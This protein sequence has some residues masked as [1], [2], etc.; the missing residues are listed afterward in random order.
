MFA[1]AFTLMS[2]AD[3]ALAYDS[4]KAL[5]RAQEATRTMSALESWKLAGIVVGATLGGFIAAGLGL[6][7]PLFLQSIP[8][9]ISSIVALSLVEA[10][11]GQGSLKDSSPRRYFAIVS[12]GIGYL[13][14]HPALRAMTLDMISA[15]AAAWLI[16]WTFQP[17]LTRSGVPI[18]SFGVMQ[19]AMALGQI[20]LLA[21]QQ[22]VEKLVG[23][24]VPMLRLTAI[25]P[26]LGFLWL[27]ATSH[28][29]PSI[30][31]ILIVSSFGLSRGPLFSGA[32]NRHIPSEERATVLSAVSAARTLAIAL[33]YP[34]AG[35]LMDLSLP[36]ALA[37]FGGFGL[38]VAWLC[39]APRSV[40]EPAE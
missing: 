12:G 6:R 27:A 2:G 38:L 9:L 4:L 31:G 32:L 17:Q 28:P 33:I 29:V 3:E 25:L 26:A 39:A 37:S 36:G 21:R 15:G 24:L 10:P 18:A 23:G 8:A 19:S 30:A 1:A 13:R 22:R 14:N 7:A 11:G 35:M 34:I 20:A 5:G 16:L 40:I